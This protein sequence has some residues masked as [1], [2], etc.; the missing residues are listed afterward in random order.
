MKT[1][2][3]HRTITCKYLGPT[4]TRGSRI[5]VRWGDYTKG[6][7]KQVFASWCSWQSV[8]ENYCAAAREFINHATNLVED[9]KLELLGGHTGDGAVFVLRW[10]RE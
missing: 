4:N 2:L 5:R 8:D 3:M 9:E 10:G 7:D 6:K 1:T